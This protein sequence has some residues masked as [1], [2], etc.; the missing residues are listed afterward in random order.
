MIQRL[1]RIALAMLVFNLWLW[2]AFLAHNGTYEQMRA[3][4]VEWYTCIDW[5]ETGH[6][7][8][9]NQCS[10]APAFDPEVI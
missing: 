8:P 2:F 3:A 4:G 10:A 1:A 5:D 9:S 7:H 6:A